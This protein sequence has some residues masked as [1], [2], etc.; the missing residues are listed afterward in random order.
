MS[1]IILFVRLLSYVKKIL[2]KCFNLTI[3][4]LFV[5][6]CLL[7]VVCCLLFIVCCLLFVVCCL[8]LFCCCEVMGRQTE[9]KIES[10]EWKIAIMGGGGVG[11]S[12]LTL[13]YCLVCFVC[14]L[15]WEIVLSLR[16]CCC[17]LRCCLLV[18]GWS[19]VRI[20]SF[21]FFLALFCGGIRPNNRR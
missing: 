15:L 2:T 18:V 7:F 16:Y 13:R 20:F 3:C 21:F 10:K 19:G 8:L 17:W 9:E 5:V 14:C 4:C 12:A 11:K 1:V 6:C